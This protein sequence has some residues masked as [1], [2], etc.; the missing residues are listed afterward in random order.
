M[1]KTIPNDDHL[2]YTLLSFRRRSIG[3]LRP[4]RHTNDVENSPYFINPL[5]PLHRFAAYLWV[6]SARIINKRAQN[7][8]PDE[9]TGCVLPAEQNETRIIGNQ[10]RLN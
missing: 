6:F 4:T 10:I 1:A 3:S 9:R 5:T 2:I 8:F 7:F